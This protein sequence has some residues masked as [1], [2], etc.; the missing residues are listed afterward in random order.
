MAQYASL[1]GNVV[2]LFLVQWSSYI[3]PLITLPYL[4]RVL[5]PEKFGL[6]AFAQGFVQYFSLLT[7]YGFNLSATRQIAVNRSSNDKIS[8][9]FCATMLIKIILMI[10]SLF[11]MG[12]VVATVPK[13]R[14]DWSVYFIAFLSV[15]GGV[16]FPTW[17]FQGM[18]QMR[19]ISIVSIATKLLSS[20]AIFILVHR[21][22]DYLIA[23][24][25]QSGGLLVVG[26]L[27]IGFVWKVAPVRLR[28]PSKDCLKET[29]SEGWHIFIS[30]AAISLYTTSNIF[31]LGMLTNNVTVGYFSVADKL[32]T[33]VKNIS[34][35]VSQAIYPRI[36]ALAKESKTKALSLIHRSLVW[37]GTSMFI[38]SCLLLVFATQL[39]HILIGSKFEPSIVL[40]QWMAF[41]P[42]LV[43]LSNIFGIQTMLTF[44]M[45]AEFSRI[46]IASGL[47]NLAL[48][49]P[50]CIY[51]GAAGA[52]IAVTV[53]ETLVTVIMAL[54]ISNRGYN[55][56]INQRIVYES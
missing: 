37:L 33:S 34:G 16:F 44:G 11:V 50:L 7:D 42:F 47:I 53:T 9:I 54:F 21:E 41:L 55:P 30:T 56:F 27:G 49:F 19:Y 38:V 43:A 52:A 48:L 32:V 22:G 15:P 4:V 24:A 28:F 51:W 1:K 45:K 39:V 29:L 25:L 23:T 10:S 18:E 17:F 8:E 26:L 5:G 46:L 6:L 35:P 40:V 36:S 20:I 31:I 12:A 13:F 14:H 2:S 3:I